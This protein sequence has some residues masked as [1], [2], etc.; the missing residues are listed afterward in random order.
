M[1]NFNCSASAK[2]RFWSSRILFPTDE[3]LEA[4]QAIPRK[5][6]RRKCMN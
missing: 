4:W 3:I 2:R 5:G 6:R 1:H